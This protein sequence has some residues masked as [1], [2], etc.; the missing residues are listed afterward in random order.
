MNI[1]LG[2][3]I[4]WILGFIIGII[5]WISSEKEDENVDGFNQ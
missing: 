1:I 5:G 2:I 3:I 4:L